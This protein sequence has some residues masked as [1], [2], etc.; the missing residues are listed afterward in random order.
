MA[1]I[2]LGV[3]SFLPF[4]IFSFIKSNCRD[5]IANDEW[6][7]IH[8]TSIHWIIRFQGNAAILP[9]AATE[10]RNSSRVLRCTQL[11][12][13]ALPEKAI[14]NAVKDYRKQLQTCQPTVDIVNAKCDNSHNRY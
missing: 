5:F 10:A 4:L 13:S 7:P 6:P 9:Q 3:L 12:S 8:P 11:I 2:V 14:D 1:L